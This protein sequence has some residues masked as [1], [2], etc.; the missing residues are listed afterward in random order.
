M[1]CTKISTEKVERR[2]VDNG[3]CKACGSEV[4]VIGTGRSIW[5]GDGHTM[6]GGGEVATVVEAYCPECDGKPVVPSY[7]T[8]IC[9]NEIVEIAVA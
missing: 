6:G 5:Y 1:Y 8:P 2:G 4:L 7:G 9:E 3:R